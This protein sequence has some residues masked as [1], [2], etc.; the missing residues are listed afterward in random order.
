MAEIV[1]RNLS[2]EKRLELVF[3]KAAALL[4]GEAGNPKSGSYPV[5]AGGKISGNGGIEGTIRRQM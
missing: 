5:A 3:T 1:V 2:L 4:P